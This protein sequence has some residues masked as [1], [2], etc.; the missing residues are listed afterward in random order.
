M[1]TYTVTIGGED[2][3]KG[4]ALAASDRF[5]RARSQGLPVM[6]HDD[7]GNCVDSGNGHGGIVRSLAAQERYQEE[8][9][10]ERGARL[11]RAEDRAW[12]KIRE[13]DAE[14]L[15]RGE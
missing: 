1:T 11:A 7:E 13:R 2:V 8:M 15:R 4:S 10:N 3:L 12:E 9:D 14:Y 5:E 6:I